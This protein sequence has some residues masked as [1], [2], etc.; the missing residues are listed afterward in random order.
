MSHF[1]TLSLLI[2]WFA[3][4]ISVYTLVH[5]R[6]LQRDANDLQKATS[7]LSK[8][9]LQLIERD[10]SDRKRVRL[11]LKLAGIPGARLLK[12]RNVGAVEAR[13][14]Q[15]ETAAEQSPFVKTQVDSL[16][17]LASLRPGEEMEMVAALFQDSPPKFQIRVK[18]LNPDDTEGSDAFEL[19]H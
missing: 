4:V 9:Q 16:F 13:R 19:V 2:P 12:L 11:S 6:K 18:W 1:E 8:R 17:P 5:Q 10:E 15:V 3:L 7:E 14:V